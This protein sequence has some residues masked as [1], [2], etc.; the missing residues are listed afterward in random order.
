MRHPHLS[1]WSRIRFQF[2]WDRRCHHSIPWA[3]ASPLGNDP[4]C[5]VLV[6]NVDAR[7]LNAMPSQIPAR[8]PAPAVPGLLC[9][10]CSAGFPRS[11]VPARGMSFLSALLPS[12]LDWHACCVM[13]TQVIV[14]SK[15][16]Q[17]GYTASRTSWSPKVALPKTKLTDF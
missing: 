11:E 3:M 4:R 2:P 7:R 10:V 6:M 8:V 5:L 14:I 1:T 9:D 13:L 15:N 16:S 12:P 17:T